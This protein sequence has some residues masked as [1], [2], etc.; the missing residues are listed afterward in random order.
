[1]CFLFRFQSSNKPS[2]GQFFSYMAILKEQPS[3][4]SFF[5]Q[6]VGGNQACNLTTHPCHFELLQKWIRNTSWI[7]M[8]KWKA[9]IEAFI[10]ESEFSKKKNWETLF[11]ECDYN[12]SIREWRS[13]GLLNCS[14]PSHGAGYTNIYM[15]ENL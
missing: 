4:Q 6:V 3:F 15:Y 10:R 12:N 13:G 8:N 5:L 1:M 11:G 14:N 2:L 7:K 9:E